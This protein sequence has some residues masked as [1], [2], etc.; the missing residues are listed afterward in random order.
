LITKTALKNI[1]LTIGY[2]SEVIKED[3]FK[4]L[5]GNFSQI[6]RFRQQ[7]FSPKKYPVQ[8]LKIL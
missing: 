1:G 5:A 2:P 6:W 7:I 3:T 8:A 4:K